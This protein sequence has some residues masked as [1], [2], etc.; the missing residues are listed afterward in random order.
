MPDWTHSTNSLEEM[1]KYFGFAV[2][3]G[4]QTHFSQ[5]TEY[6]YIFVKNDRFY[7]YVYSEN[8][9]I[10]MENAVNSWKNGDGK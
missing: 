4:W 9:I 7:A 10:W 1:R 8:P 5:W 6:L 3:M 2:K